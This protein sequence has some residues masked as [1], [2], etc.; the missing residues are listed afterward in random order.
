MI[1][2]YL[3]YIGVH[4]AASTDHSKSDIKQLSTKLHWSYSMYALNHSYCI[5]THWTGNTFITDIWDP[6]S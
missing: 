3:G 2:R 1:H 4:S 6:E 5:Y